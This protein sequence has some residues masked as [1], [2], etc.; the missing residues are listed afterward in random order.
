MAIKL[1]FK[2]PLAKKMRKGFQGYP[3]ATIAYYG[4]TNNMATKVVA[5]IVENETDEPCIQEKWYSEKDLRRN[6]KI[7]NEIKDFISTHN[8][9]SAIVPNKI[10]GC[11]HQEGIDYPEGEQCE[12]CTFWKNRDRWTCNGSA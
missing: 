11:P 1:K 4:P 6:K 2:S 5:S 3:L 10:I 7:L 9:K 8:V 12:E